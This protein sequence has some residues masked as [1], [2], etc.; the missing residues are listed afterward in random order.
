MELPR[1][2]RTREV[3]IETENLSRRF[4]HLVAVRD[5]SLRVYRGE[6][7]GVLG[8]NG[9]GKSTTIRMLCGIL[10]PSS[11]RGRVVGYDIATRVRAHQGAHRLHDA[12]LQPVRGP[13]RRREPRLLRAAS[14]ASPAKQRRARIEVGARADRAARAQATSSPARSPAAGSSASRWRARRSTSRRC[15]SSTSRPPASTRSAAASSGIRSTASRA[16]ARPCSSPRTTW[17]RPS[18]AI[19]WRSSSAASCSAIGTPE[20]GRRRARS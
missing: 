18:A 15:C 17:T 14:T 8:P 19:G 7:F 5:V 16:R 11:G 10:D 1:R 12:A 3:V 9:A 6:I 20:R 2:D 13:D 4:G